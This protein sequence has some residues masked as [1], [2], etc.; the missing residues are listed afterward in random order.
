LEALLPGV[1]P[2]GQG[3]P[4]GIRLMTISISGSYMEDYDTGVPWS[5]V[6][7]VHGLDIPYVARDGSA[8]VITMPYNVEASI[9]RLFPAPDTLT[10]WDMQ[11]LIPPGGHAQSRRSG[12]RD[13]RRQR[14]ASRV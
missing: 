1:A 6:S 7:G 12:D 2:G 14:H 5:L 8:Q 10:G 13:G 4:P 11:K 3:T 9:N